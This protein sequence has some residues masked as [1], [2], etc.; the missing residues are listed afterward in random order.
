M[1]QTTDAI[2]SMRNA[3]LE[4]SVD[5]ITWMDISGFVNS[6]DPSGHERESGEVYT[7]AGDEAIVGYGKLSPAET[8]CGIVYTEPVADVYTLAWNAKINATPVYL[9]ATPKG[10]NPGNMAWTSKVG[11]IIACPPPSGE[12]SS[13]DPITVEFTHRCAGWTKAALTT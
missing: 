2:E 8:T 6:I 1:P 5:A 4:W 10:D 9:R 7:M 3:F 13:G 12:A 11:K